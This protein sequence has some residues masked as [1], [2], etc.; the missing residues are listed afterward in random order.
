MEVSLKTA[1]HLTALCLLV[2]ITPRYAFGL[3]SVRICS[4]WSWCL[5]ILCIWISKFHGEHSPPTSFSGRH[6]AWELPVD[7]TPW[8][9]ACM[10]D[11]QCNLQLVEKD[12]DF[13]ETNTYG[14]YQSLWFFV[15]TS[16]QTRI[17]LQLL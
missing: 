15:L 17:H 12:F 6:L 5:C 13:V 7:K 1:D 11:H 2:H 8:D 16:T 9:M 3:R 14:L 4:S 10:S